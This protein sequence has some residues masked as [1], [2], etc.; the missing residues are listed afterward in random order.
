M[1]IAPSIFF[2]N[3]SV[4]KEMFGNTPRKPLCNYKSVKRVRGEKYNFDYDDDDISVNSEGS[5]SGYKIRGSYTSSNLHVHD[6]IKT[7]VAS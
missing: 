1:L 2:S 3:L 7:Y 6:D 5:A 4:D